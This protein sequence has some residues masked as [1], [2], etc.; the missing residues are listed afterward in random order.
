MKNYKIYTL[1]DPITN[2]IKYVGQTCQSLKNRLKKHL[3]SK[4]KSYRT[5]WIKSLLLKNIEPTINLIIDNL[6]KDECNDLEK[7]YIKAFKENGIKLVNM[8]EGG[9]GSFGFKHSE[10]TKRELSKIR[11]ELNTDERKEH[12]RICGIKQWENATE[13]EKLNNIIN[14]PARKDILQCDMNGNIIKEFMS[15]RQIERELGYFRANISP[16]LKG[17][18]KKS[19][20]FIWKYK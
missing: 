3:N 4:D 20:G 15:L 2:E 10:K 8:T 5:N 11:K 19:Y 1:N 12:L 16:C 13:E 14:Q 17:I 7:F 18:S 6:N 9:E